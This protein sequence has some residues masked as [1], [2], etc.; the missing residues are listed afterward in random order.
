MPSLL[1]SHPLRTST[2]PK[3][4]P[5]QQQP[6]LSS[7]HIDLWEHAALLYHHFE[8]QT[9]IETFQH[10]FHTIP[11]SSSEART[12]CL[13]NA[14]I[15]QARLGD[16]ALAA[17]TLEDA[18][19]TDGEFVLTPFLLGIVEWELG[20]LIKAEACLEI[21][22]V[23]LRR[24]KGEREVGGFPYGVGFMFR[25]EIVRDMLERL[26]GV[27]P[28]NEE[29]QS[30]I[31]GFAVLEAEF[32]FEAPAREGELE[33]VSAWRREKEVI[34]TGKTSISRQSEH[35]SASLKPA[36]KN[37]RETFQELKSF[38]RGHKPIPPPR[39]SKPGVLTLL[40]PSRPPQ[41]PTAKAE[42]TY[43]STWRRRPPTPYIPRDARGEYHSVGELAR[44]I[45]RY[46]NQVEPMSPR[47]PR[48]EAES[49]GELARF[50]RC[51]G[52]EGGE[53]VGG[54]RMPFLEGEE[55]GGLV[56]VGEVESLLDLYLVRE[57][58]W[59]GPWGGGGG[60]GGGGK[61]GG[62]YGGEGENNA[63]P[64]SDPIPARTA[65]KDVTGRVERQILTDPNTPTSSHYPSS[66]S[67]D[68]EDRASAETITLL[69]PKVYE[70]AP[71]TTIDK[72][73][74]LTRLSLQLLD[75]SPSHPSAE[76]DN[77]PLANFHT[78]GSETSSLFRQSMLTIERAQVARSEALRRLEGRM[79]VGVKKN[80]LLG[81]GERGRGGKWEQKRK[82]VGEQGEE[83]LR[84]GWFNEGRRGGNGGGV[85]TITTT[86]APSA[87]ETKWERDPK[88]KDGNDGNGSDANDGKGK[89]PPP[90]PVKTAPA[91]SPAGEGG[92]I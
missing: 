49:T 59:D 57:D 42:A 48:G 73:S 13:L 44:F 27:D 20:N 86:A 55:P 23:A 64:Y 18:A 58:G 41:P 14:G 81:R 80:G 82:W 68:D 37:P 3:Q 70:G 75:P 12:R 77:N 61:G 50:V 26:R 74:N 76:D 15:I 24:Y 65:I 34:S 4:P 11:T 1:N 38:L 33:D 85:P 78:A 87:V 39:P 16:Y 22:L 54:L 25:E 29:A 35:L 32:I 2:T 69:L 17:Q 19:R 72:P 62:G 63:R 51:A 90:F 10:L 84:N 43:H 88:R 71:P 40:D 31:V 91:W 83:G 45:R 21:S 60:G 56:D 5:P 36:V 92:S 52:R 67:K 89:L 46:Q 9:A 47:D 53:V 8:W 7:A 30:T 6:K 79:R 66:S 28:L